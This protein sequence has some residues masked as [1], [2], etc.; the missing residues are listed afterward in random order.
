ME[1]GT[2][3]QVFISAAIFI[4]L[5]V[6]ALAMLNR[7]SSIQNTWINR[8]SHRTM[9][10]LWG[11]SEKIHKYFS[12][13]KQ[14]QALAEENFE[15][16]RKLIE[17]ESLIREKEIL[18]SSGILESGRFAMIP[19]RI[20][21]IS[22]NQQQNYIILDKGAEDGVL[23]NSGIMTSH[24]VVGIISAVDKHYSYGMSF[25]N[26]NFSVSARVGK[27]G[28]TAPMQWTGEGLGNAII[29][30]LPRHYKVE[31]GDTVWT[32]GFSDFFPSGIPLGTVTETVLTFG[33]TSESHVDLFQDFSSLDYVIIL[34]ACFQDELN[35]IEQ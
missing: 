8:I 19:A 15:L 13:D 1:R 5:E 2:R 29:R 16:T 3:R 22:R 21:R 28:M 30:D 14:N 25:L 24:G 34:R 11:G 26:S 9:A 4:V 6:A 10:M 17:Y 23:P 35:Q 12:L 7:S 32:S 27:G 33:A 31:P 20:V 18:D